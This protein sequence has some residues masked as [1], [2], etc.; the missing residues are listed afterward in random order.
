MKKP[1]ELSR[2]EL[3]ELVEQLLEAMFEHIKY[4]L[5]SL[6]EGLGWEEEYRTLSG[7]QRMELRNKLMSLLWDEVEEIKEELLLEA[8]AVV[9]RFSLKHNLEEAAP[10]ELFEALYYDDAIQEIIT[11]YIAEKI[12]R[13]MEEMSK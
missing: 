1:Q 7:S 9:I 12:A 11:T 6:M 8:R 3:E 4:D 5:A 2:K 10:Y 13:E